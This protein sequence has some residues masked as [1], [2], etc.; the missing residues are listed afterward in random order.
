MRDSPLPSQ[1]LSNFR[2]ASLPSFQRKLEPRLVL[3]L[4]TPPRKRNDNVDPGL[5]SHSAVENRRDDDQ[6]LLFHFP[7]ISM[8]KHYDADYFQRWYRDGD[9]GGA[10]RLARKVALAVAVAEYHLERPIRT[11]LD[12][13][14][15]EG[16][17]RGPLLKLR[18][19]LQYLGFDSSEYA[20]RRFGRTRNLHYARFEDFQY[21]RPCEPVDLLVCSD[22]LH[23]VPTRELKRGLTGLAELCGGVA[24]LETFAKEDDFEG[25]HDGFQSRRAAWYR[26]A[27]NGEGFQSVGNHCW[28]G[29]RLAGD[30]AVLEAADY[31][32]IT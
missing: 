2:D 3:P 25:D 20:I 8:T 18:P 1:G 28:L 15:G 27:F 29:P 32:P 19:K 9:I 17:W 26:Q 12:I 23:Y 13:G 16:A 5:T 6:A 10:P 21:L 31:R 4:R 24:F 14:C 7:R 30:V 11:V 22:V